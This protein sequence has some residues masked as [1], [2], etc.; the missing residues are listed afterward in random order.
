MPRRAAGG[1]VTP[2]RRFGHLKVV[3]AGLRYGVGQPGHPRGWPAA[4]CRCHAPSLG[5]GTCG[6]LVVVA[7]FRLL[8]GNTT[9]CGCQ[10]C[11]RP[12]GSPVWDRIEAYLAARGGGAWF[13][14][15]AAGAELPGGRAAHLQH[16][17]TAGRLQRPVR[18]F[19]HL[20]G[21]CPDPIPPRQAVP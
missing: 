6:A 12:H 19:Y 16:M 2:R 18:G 7:N 3:R 8:N 13:T 21:R 20:P 14:E 17:M 4:Q 15:I 5:D 10:A 9:S 1:T 11:W